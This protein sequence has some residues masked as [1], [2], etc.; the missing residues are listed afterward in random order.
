MKWKQEFYK[1][2]RACIHVDDTHRLSPTFIYFSQQY[3]KKSTRSVRIGVTRADDE[4]KQLQKSAARFFSLSKKLFN[5]V[6]T[7][8][9]PCFCM[10][11][12]YF[13]NFI[14]VEFYYF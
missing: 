2:S 14:P 3:E 1:R 8:S 10:E 4:W 12:V 9:G 6:N 11:R 5:G 7:T 13:I